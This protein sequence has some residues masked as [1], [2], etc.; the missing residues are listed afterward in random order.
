MKKYRKRPIVVEAMR[1]DGSE[2]GKETL[3][4][5][6]CP[7]KPFAYGDGII[8]RTPFGSTGCAIGDWIVK[9]IA[10]EFYRVKN[11]IFQATHEEVQDETQK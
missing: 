3:L 10:G 9:D 7:F 6:G 11:E 4:Q 5:W 8:I 1:F 2:R